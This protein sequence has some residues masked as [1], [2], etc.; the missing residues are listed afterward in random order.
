MMGQ[1][2]AVC[3]PSMETKSTPSVPGQ[4]AGAAAPAAAW[5]THGL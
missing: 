2:I 1:P 4:A 3:G 5:T